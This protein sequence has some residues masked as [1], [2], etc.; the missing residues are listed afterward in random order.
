MLLASLFVKFEGT[1]PYGYQKQDGS[2]IFKCYDPCNPPGKAI[3][4]G[5]NKRCLADKI[6]NGIFIGRCGLSES[7]RNTSI[8]K[9][10]KVVGLCETE[11]PRFY[12]NSITK[13]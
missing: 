8:C 1:C 9:E 6:S 10:E 3:L 7:K 4:C 12:Y 5:S 13:T 11:F 2:E